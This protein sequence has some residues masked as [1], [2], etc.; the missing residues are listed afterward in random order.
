MF[1]LELY[2]RIGNKLSLGDIVKVSDGKGISFYAEVKYLESE[3]VIAPFHTFSFHSF[4]KVDSVPEHAKKANEERYNIWY[5][6]SPELND[7]EAAE[8]A[9][10]YL[11]SWR[12]CE[13]LI[14]KRCFRIEPV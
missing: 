7:K 11:M 12:Q 3:K 4:E 13:H 14:E 8:Y 10:E 6:N 1:R 9:N 2:D 5:T